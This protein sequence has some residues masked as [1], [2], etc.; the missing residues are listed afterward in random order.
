MVQDQCKSCLDVVTPD[1]NFDLNDDLCDDCF[2]RKDMAAI[3]HK[4][5]LE[6]GDFD[7]SMNY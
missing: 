3:R 7:Y 6:S 5:C 1:N 4:D 2:A